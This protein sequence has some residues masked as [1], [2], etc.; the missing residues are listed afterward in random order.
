[1]DN[2]IK[3]TLK[4]H[5][6]DDGSN[7]HCIEFESDPTVSEL[8]AAVLVLE[9]VLEHNFSKQDILLKKG[10]I[11]PRLEDLEEIRREKE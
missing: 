1:M 8:C 4:D 7:I 3:I 5:K 11:Y 2:V 6:K 9:E 10:T